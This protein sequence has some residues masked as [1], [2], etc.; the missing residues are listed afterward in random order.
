ML[1]IVDVQKYLARKKKTRQK[2]LTLRLG[3]VSFVR[4]VS[5]NFLFFFMGWHWFWTTTPAVFFRW[6]PES[7]HVSLKPSSELLARAEHAEQHGKKQGSSYQYWKRQ[8]FLAKIAVD[9]FSRI[10]KAAS[11][12]HGACSGNFGALPAWCLFPTCESS[13]ISST[14]IKLL[15]RAFPINLQFAS[16]CILLFANLRWVA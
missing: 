2:R 14:P 4:C 16:T 8:L 13:Q 7:P 9:F 10:S 5:Q 15:T 1:Q 11:P 3:R 12:H 6:R